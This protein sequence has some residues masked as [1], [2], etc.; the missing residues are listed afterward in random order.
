MIVKSIQG[1]N[2]YNGRRNLHVIAIAPNANS[3]ILLGTSPSIEPSSAN[4][5]N[6]QTRAGSWLVKNRYL[7]SLLETK[8]MNTEEVWSEIIISKGSVQ[9]LEC[10]DDSEKK[11]FKTAIELD[12]MWVIQ[13]AADRQ[14][15]ICQAQSVNLFFPPNAD[16]PYM[17]KVHTAA[18]RKGLK[19][20]YYVRTMTPFMV[21]SVSK[22]LTRIALKDGSASDIANVEQAINRSNLTEPVQQKVKQALFESVN[23][24]GCASCEG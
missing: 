9:N 21:G 8:H 6:H 22:K 20:V 12:Q 5:Y 2:V 23:N 16:R 19:S 15:F 1:K 11:V 18:W 4:A 3:S 17:N 13:H 24:D 7:E 10:L 14:P